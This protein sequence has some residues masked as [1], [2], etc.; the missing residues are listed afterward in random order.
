MY[1]YAYRYALKASSSSHLSNQELLQYYEQMQPSNIIR[2]YR[3]KYFV[4]FLAH[5]PLE[6]Q[7][8]A[9]VDYNSGNLGW[10]A[11]ILEDLFAVYTASPHLQALLP[12]PSF[13][14][15]EWREFLLTNS[16]VFV[17]ELCKLDY[18]PI[19]SNTP[20]QTCD[21]LWDNSAGTVD[22]HGAYFPC[23]DCG[24]VFKSQAALHG[25]T[26][27]VHAFKSPIRRYA[28]STHC[29]ACL[30]EFSIRPRLLRHLARKKNNYCIN[31][32]HQFFTPL[33]M[34]ESA[35]LDSQDL[36]GI[37]ALTKLLYYRT[38]PTKLYPFCRSSLRDS[39]AGAGEY[40][41]VGPQGFWG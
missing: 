21:F 14:S 37:K 12:P 33:S 1:F 3:L 28:Y 40:M 39:G 6:L 9:A 25:H 7:A 19:D 30:L 10:A 16:N 41:G 2:K 38:I 24:K 31:Y 20:S 18:V 11:L 13:Y 35:A 34:D 27:K 8:L 32:L 17:K 26:S 23:R 22:V 29:A 36:V 5:A 15:E 4:R